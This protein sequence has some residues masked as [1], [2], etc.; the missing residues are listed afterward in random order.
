M[1]NVE[2]V[3]YNS[4]DELGDQGGVNQLAGAA[5]HGNAHHSLSMFDSELS[6]NKVNPM[7]PLHH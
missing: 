1:P 6:E 5:A 2:Q 4:F 7:M 3:V